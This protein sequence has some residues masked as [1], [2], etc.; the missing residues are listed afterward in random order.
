VNVFITGASSGIG[1]ALAQRYAAR[2]ACLGLVGRRT[3]LLDELVQSLPAKGAPH[4]VYGL[5]ITIPGALAKAAHAFMAAQGT[6][7]VVIANAGISLGTRSEIEDDLDPFFRTIETNLLAT[8][9]TF[10]PFIGPM[11]LLPTARLV[12]IGSVAGIRGLPGASAYCA[13]KAAVISYCESL[14]VE[15][16]A[17][18][19]RVVTLAPGYIATPMTVNNPY[20]MPF[21]MPV[22]AF[23]RRALQVIDRGQS[24][25]V[26]PWQM[27]GIAKVLRIM[28]N[29]LYDRAFSHAPQKPRRSV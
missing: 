7:E 25:A 23:A 22:D 26:I 28:P 17:S 14:R 19:I 5:D 12:G 16:R 9:T 24:Y 3:A 8:V 10:Q 27:A 18:P 11:R 20:P 1:R 29:W 15:L 2:G 21:L 13:S 4:H 6:P